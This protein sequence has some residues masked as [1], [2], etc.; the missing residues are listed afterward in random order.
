MVE[1]KTTTPTTITTTTTTNRKK[2]RKKNNNY[3]ITCLFIIFFFFFLLFFHCLL[4]SGFIEIVIQFYKLRLV[5]LTGKH[6]TAQHNQNT[7]HSLV[8]NVIKPKQHSVKSTTNKFQN[9][10]KQKA[11]TIDQPTKVCMRVVGFFFWSPSLVAG[12]SNQMELCCCCCRFFRAM[13]MSHNG[14][15]LQQQQ[16]Q[17]IKSHTQESK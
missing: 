14:Q 11:K 8:P 1:M 6:S 15:I 5:Y 9:S 7:G 3:K 13:R 4:D 10:T 2:N 16:Q 17:K 12:L